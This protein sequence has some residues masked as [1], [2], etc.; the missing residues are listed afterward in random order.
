MW[1]WIATI[2]ANLFLCLLLLFRGHYKRYKILFLSLV[3]ELLAAPL[4]YLIYTHFGTH[5]E[6]Y[7]AAFHGKNF[8]TILFCFGI[9][10][11]GVMWQNRC[12][13][14]PQEIYLLALIAKFV[15]ERVQYFG[16]SHLIYE[17]VRYSGIAILGWYLWC[18]RKDSPHERRAF[19]TP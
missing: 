4:L 2:A 15:A 7:S 14:I 1:I 3:F 11:E 9:L 12:L 19:R 16:V 6:E 13:R 8:I 5:S 18:F 10:W 17:V